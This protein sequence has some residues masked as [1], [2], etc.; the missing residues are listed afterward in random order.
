[1]VFFNIYN[2]YALAEI[3]TMLILLQIQPTKPDNLSAIAKGNQI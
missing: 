1:V 3:K 2:D